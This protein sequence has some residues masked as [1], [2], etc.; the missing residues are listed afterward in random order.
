MWRFAAIS[1]CKCKIR[2]DIGEVSCRYLN[3]ADLK[4]YTLRVCE[5]YTLRI[6]KV[7]NLRDLTWSFDI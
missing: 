3:V 6:F 4:L 1:M 7:Y 2:I 5:L